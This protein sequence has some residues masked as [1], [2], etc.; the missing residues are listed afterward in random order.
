M[1]RERCRELLPV[2]QA[3]AEGKEIQWRF[4]DADNTSWR[5]EW[6]TASDE[7][8][9]SGGVDCEYRIKP[10]S[11]VIYAVRSKGSSKNRTIVENAGDWDEDV[12]DIK[13]YQEVL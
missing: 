7:E 13:K 9:I 4:V 8:G 6:R 12:W 2:I 1:N 11:E 3:F 10:E 5:I